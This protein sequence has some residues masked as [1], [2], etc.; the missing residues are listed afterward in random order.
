MAS[1]AM[2]TEKETSSVKKACLVENCY[3]KKHE[4]FKGQQGTLRKIKLVKHMY[5]IKN[6]VKMEESGLCSI[7]NSC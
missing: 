2:E 7:G 6:T 5:N 1:V 3:I 4:S